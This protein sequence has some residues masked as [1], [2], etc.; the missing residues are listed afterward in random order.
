LAT[1]SSQVTEVLVRWSNG[2]AAA[3]E[4]LVPLVYD[5]F[6]R[7]ARIFSQGAKS[8]LCKARRGLTKPI[9]VW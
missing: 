3:R 1:D 8:I 6:Q 5:E 4:L 2:D 9:F 7:L